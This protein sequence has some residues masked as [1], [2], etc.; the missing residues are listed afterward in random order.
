MSDPKVWVA[1]RFCFGSALDT[2]TFHTHP[3]CPMQTRSELEERAKS[4]CYTQ[5]QEQEKCK[6]C[7]RLIDEER[8]ERQIQHIT[9]D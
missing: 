7:Q 4:W 2:V 5:F 1:E 3:E 6:H 9:N 8:I